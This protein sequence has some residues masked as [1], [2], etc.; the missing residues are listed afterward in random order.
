MA[1]GLRK[2]PA[3]ERWATM[4]ND[5]NL[6]FRPTPMTVVIGLVT[7]VAIPVGLYYGI[8]WGEVRP[9]DARVS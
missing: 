7:L 4:R 9:L 3:I 1:G 5:A 2:D 8:Q 6:Y